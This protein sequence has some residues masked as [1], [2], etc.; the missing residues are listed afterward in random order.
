MTYRELKT[1]ID[2]FTESQL[3]QQIA[4]FEGDDEVAKLIDSVEISTEDWYFDHTDCL[5][6]LQSIKEE[7][8][9][10]WQDI[11]DDATLV[12]AGTVSL[13]INS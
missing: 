3:N 7:N 6:N 12:P 11:I 13:Q 9:D 10:D 8:P 2:S 5:G 4:V 1:K